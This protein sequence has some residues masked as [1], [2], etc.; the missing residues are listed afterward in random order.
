MATD[1]ELGLRVTMLTQGAASSRDFRRKPSL[2][3]R[4]CALLVRDRASRAVP[5]SAS[6][7]VTDEDKVWGAIQGLANS[8]GDP[9]TVF[10][11]PADSEIFNDDIRGNFGGVGME[12]GIRDDNLTVI[13]PLEGTPAKAAGI[14]SGDVIFRIDGESTDDLRIDEAVKLIRGEKGT[15]VAL[16]IEREGESELLEIEVVRASGS[17][18]HEFS[19]VR[20][21]HCKHAQRKLFVGFTCL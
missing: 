2:A 12:I 20:A 8:T 14:Q 5:T 15:A 13:A 6:S 17:G 16:T 7:T 1:D 3:T 19:T 9:Y 10:L 4:L 11:P 18:A 21:S